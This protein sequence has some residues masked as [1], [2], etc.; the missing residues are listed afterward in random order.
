MRFFLPAHQ[1]RIG[2]VKDIIVGTP[3]PPPQFLFF[4]CHY[5][6][7]PWEDSLPPCFC[8]PQKDCMAEWIC[9]RRDSLGIQQMVF[10]WRKQRTVEKILLIIFL[11]EPI[12]PKNL[13]TVHNAQCMGTL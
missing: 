4:E 6:S 8:G 3:P 12:V 11:S 1:G 7:T 5:A 10:L 2:L 13:P 9:G